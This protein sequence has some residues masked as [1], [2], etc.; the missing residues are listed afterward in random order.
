MM[1]EEGVMPIPEAAMEHQYL[2]QDKLCLPDQLL[3]GWLQLLLLE[4]YS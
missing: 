4:E 1:A 3:G 2:H